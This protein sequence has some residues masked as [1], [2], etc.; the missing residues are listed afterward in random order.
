MGRLAVLPDLGLCYTWARFMNW[1]LRGLWYEGYGM[2]A[3]LVG[4]A[5][6]MTYQLLPPKEAGMRAVGL[7]PNTRFSRETL[8]LSY[9]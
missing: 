8:L 5:Q 6:N 1:A 4:L 9:Q 3:T 2:W 7:R